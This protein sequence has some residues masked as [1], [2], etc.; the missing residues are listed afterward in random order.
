MK[1]QF[2][3]LKSLAAIN[4]LSEAWSRQSREPPHDANCSL[5]GSARPPFLQKPTPRAMPE[6]GTPPAAKAPANELQ[7]AFN[8]FDKDGSGKIDKA[9]LKEAL[10]KLG[11]E[12]ADAKLDEY[13][14]RVDVNNDGEV[15]MS[16][17]VQLACEN[18]FR[19]TLPV[20]TV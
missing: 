15:D 13:I 1:C 18:R 17:F 20:S 5:E 3:I 11:H 19:L 12:P 9:E 16:E 8:E 7:E 6:E 14:T 10:K 2:I 4:M